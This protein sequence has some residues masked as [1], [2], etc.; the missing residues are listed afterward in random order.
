MLILKTIL[1]GIIFLLLSIAIVFN[2][3]LKYIERER[4]KN[5]ERTK[6]KNIM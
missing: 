2:I 3:I 4:K 1:L 6:K 5:I